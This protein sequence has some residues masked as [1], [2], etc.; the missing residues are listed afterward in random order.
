MKLSFTNLVW[1]SE[2]FHFLSHI[3]VMVF[4]RLLIPRYFISFQWFYFVWDLL[5]V[6]VWAITFHMPKIVQ[7]I[8]IFQ[9]IAHMG[10]VV[11]WDTAEFC[12]DIIT[13]SSMEWE[14]PVFIMDSY[15][16]IYIWGATI[17]D[18]MV[19]GLMLYYIKSNEEEKKEKVI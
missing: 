7:G 1:L 9:I 12:K 6:A 2:L 10:Y 4:G 16:F 5:S 3:F 13:W 11:N 14:K 18:I 15:H 17:F 19:H 8:C